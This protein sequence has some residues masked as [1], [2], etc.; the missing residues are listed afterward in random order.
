MVPD[1]KQDWPENSADGAGPRPPPLD[2]PGEAL[3]LAVNWP[4]NGHQLTNDARADRGDSG[5][6]LLHKGTY[7]LARDRS[8]AAGDTSS[9]PLVHIESTSAPS[10]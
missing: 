2:R 4:S 10:G 7:S 1:F 6:P 8:P 9:W 5:V 3:Q